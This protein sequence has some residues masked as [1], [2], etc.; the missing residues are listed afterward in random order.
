M[1]RLFVKAD[2][3]GQIL[4][5]AKVESLPEGQKAPFSAEDAE[6]EVI[7]IKDPKE[8]AKFIDMEVVDIHVGYSIDTKKKVLK[9]KTS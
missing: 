8:K 4:A 3:Q 6:I 7:E 5:V 9:K 2:K 1:A